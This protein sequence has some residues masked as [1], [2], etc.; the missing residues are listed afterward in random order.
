MMNPCQS[1][2]TVPR[3]LAQK[4]GGTC[5]SARR[6]DLEH[7]NQSNSNLGRLLSPNRQPKHKPPTMKPS[8][9]LSAFAA[10]ATAVT[11][12]E[13]DD[14][15]T[16]TSPPT[17][18]IAPVYIQPI[19]SSSPPV[20]L[21]ELNYHPS[22]S[23]NPSSEEDAP[24]PSVLSYEPPEFDPETKLVRV[25]VYDEKTERWASSAAVV[26]VENFG[27]GYQP[28]FVLNVDE[29]GEEVVGVVVRGV[30]VDAGQTRNFGPRVVVRGMERGRQPGLGKPVVLSAEGRKVEVEER[31]FLQKY[32][33]AILLGA[34]LLLGGG[35]DGK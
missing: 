32:W 3:R 10:L 15:V 4:L 21:A 29:K 30:R 27:Q 34:V 18:R 20:L 6:Q 16:Y 31:S 13:Y 19:S 33:W 22:S 25:G 35:G 7:H 26:S 8:H 17:G 28:N 9:L 11:A 23:T 12:Q 24:A 1:L 14:D 5:T 2:S